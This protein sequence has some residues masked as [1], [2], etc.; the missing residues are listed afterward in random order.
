MRVWQNLSLKSRDVPI[1]L[2]QRQSGP[3]RPA[4]GAN[5]SLESAV[6]QN[7]GPKMRI[8]RRNYFWWNKWQPVVVVHF[9]RQF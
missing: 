9:A 2:F 8:Q 5:L 4:R 7:R 1:G 6:C 3:D